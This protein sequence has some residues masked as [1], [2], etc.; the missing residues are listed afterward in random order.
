MPRP[1]WILTLT[2]SLTGACLALLAPGRAAPPAA[3]LIQEDPVKAALERPV[4]APGQALAELRDYCE[5]RVPRMP[6]VRSAGEW[7]RY[8]ER[9]RAETLKRVIFRGEAARWRAAKGRVE[10]LSSLPGGPGYRI[11]K[12]RYEAIPGLWVPALLYEPERPAPRVPVILNVNGHDRKGKAADYKQIRCINLAKRGMLALNVEWFGMG[13]F[14]TPAYSH[15]LINSIDL[16]GTSGIA[17]HFLMLARG[18]DLLLGL[19]HADP[20]RV[21][22]TGLS[23]GGWQTI[24]ISALDPRVTLTDPVAGYSSFR[25]RARH[26]SDLGDSEQTPCDLATV[27]DYAPMTAMMAPRATLLTFNAKDDCCFRA[28]HALPPLME[29][30]G[31]VFRLFGGEEKLRT[32]V[33]EDPG[34]HNYLLDNRQAFYRMVGDHFFADRQ[35]FDAKEIPSEPEVRTAE[36]L[37]VAVPPDNGSL[38]GLAEALSRSLPRDPALPDSRGRAERWQSARRAALREVVRAREYR[39]TAER[40]RLEEGGG[41][42]TGFWKL[43]LADDRDGLT[44]PLVEISR[45]DPKET[46]LLVAD[47]GRKGLASAARRL[48]DQ[49]R[50]VLAVDPFYLGECNPDPQRAYLWALFVATIGDRPLGLQASQLAGISRWATQERQWGPVAIAASGP[51]ASLAALAAAGLEKEAIGRL[52]LSGALGSLKEA[53]ERPIPYSQAP[54]LF[55]FGLLEAFDVRQ[56]TALVA[57]RPV[58]F[59]GAGGR[60][61]AE[62]QGLPGWFRMLGARPGALEI[63]SGAS[64][65]DDWAH[66]PTAPAKEE[67]CSGCG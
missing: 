17:T 4:L 40:V 64:A 24:F 49:G 18:I 41:L 30:A 57:P 5:R 6:A 52:E 29:A 28:G 23:G 60:P 9:T 43:S 55:C 67:G 31:P 14:N 37:Q 26:D 65:V 36:E 39:V 50:R 63:R 3:A 21:A 22:V 56:L 11:R 7:R 34:T 33:N 51:R 48:L 35:G 46:V 19:E 32:H 38:R 8:A 66:P 45:G 53:I 42:K 2:L 25:T 13:Q 27:T 58:V 16:C 54:E 12:V 59:A 62:L 44:V 1:H 47:G 10:W 20:K 61:H 15:D